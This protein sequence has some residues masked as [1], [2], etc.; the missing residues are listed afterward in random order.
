[1]TIN[2]ILIAIGVVAFI[3]YASFNIIYL[4]E[5]RRTSFAL[6]QLIKRTDE[7]LHPAFEKVRHILEDVG[8]ATDNVVA[9]TENVREIAGSVAAVEKIIKKLYG[10][11][12]KGI[13]DAT[14]AN[15][16]GLQAG[17]KTGVVTLF[18]NLIVKK[19]GSP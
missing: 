19:E 14:R 5:L 11:Y 13:S 10:S 7:N 4:I 18:E 1:M 8:K 17:V 6:R 15:I 3:I 12:K 16:A 2:E 9:L